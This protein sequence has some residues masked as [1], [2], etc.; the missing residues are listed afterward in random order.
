[1]S[2]HRCHLSGPTK[3]Q[4]KQLT[5]APISISKCLLASKLSTWGVTLSSSQQDP[6]LKILQFMGFP[7][8][9]LIPIYPCHLSHV[10]TSLASPSPLLLSFSV[11]FLPCPSLVM[12][13]LFCSPASPCPGSFYCPLLFLLDLDSFSCLCL[14]SLSPVSIINKNYQILEQPCPHLFII[15][16]QF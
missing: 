3:T 1:M 11:L 13:L 5:V 14:Y 7:S 2:F 15:H 9:L 6:Y 8:Q 10:P 4:G 16:L 12:V